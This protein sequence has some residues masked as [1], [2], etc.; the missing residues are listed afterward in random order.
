MPS[1]ELL[2]KAPD[3]S[4]LPGEDKDL[5]ADILKTVGEDWLFAKNVW[6]QDQKPDDLIGTSDEYRVRNILRSIRSAGLS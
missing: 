2:A 4:L 3:K 6:L 1:S 5:R